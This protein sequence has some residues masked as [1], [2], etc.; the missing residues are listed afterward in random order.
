MVREESSK[1][2]CAPRQLTVSNRLIF[3]ADRY[4]FRVEPDLR[5]KRVGQIDTFQHVDFSREAAGTR[6]ENRFH[7]EIS[8]RY[9]DVHGCDHI[10]QKLCSR[11]GVEA[12]ASVTQ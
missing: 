8:V 3:R 2:T 11:C 4:C 9:Q 7:V 10:L 5:N 1:R 12:V 6:K